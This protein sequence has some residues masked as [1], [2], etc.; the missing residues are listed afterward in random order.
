M[1]VASAGHLKAE[2]GSYESAV[3]FMAIVML[4]ASILVAV[5]PIPG[6]ADTSRSLGSGSGKAVL[7]LRIL[8]A[9]N[10]DIERADRDEV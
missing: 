4:A 9:E 10:N 6:A 8:P 5:F 3:L 7:R 2:T 1:R